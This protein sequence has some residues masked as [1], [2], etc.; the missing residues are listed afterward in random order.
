M[1]RPNI[2][3]NFIEYDSEEDEYDSEEENKYNDKY[4]SDDEYES[5]DNRS[6]KKVPDE[7]VPER[8]PNVK[9]Y[10]TKLPFESNY[11]NPFYI[12][13]PEPKPVP[14]PK[15]PRTWKTL[16]ETDT[17]VKMDFTVDKN[18]QE[19]QERI[20]ER[21]ERRRKTIIENR[22]KEETTQEIIDT[23][24]NA[25][26]NT[27]NEVLMSNISNDEKIKELNHEM[28][29]FAKYK[30]TELSDRPKSAEIK[31]SYMTQ[32]E[33]W[34]KLH[35]KLL[36]GKKLNT[37][38][39]TQYD[40][41][42]EKRNICECNN[43]NIAL[44][45]STI[46]NLQAEIRGEERLEKE[47]KR[48]AAEK[49]QVKRLEEAAEIKRQHEEEIY[50]N[51]I[52]RI[53]DLIQSFKE[54]YS[55]ILNVYYMNN[56]IYTRNWEKINEELFYTFTKAESFSIKIT[57]QNDKIINKAGTLLK[58]NKEIIPIYSSIE[59]EL[60]GV[61]D[62]SYISN[63]ITIASNLANMACTNTDLYSI[64]IL[65]TRQDNNIITKIIIKF[66]K[67]QQ[68]VIDGLNS[69]DNLFLKINENPTMINNQS[70]LSNA[71]KNC[72]Q[73]IIET[74][75]DIT[76]KKNK[77]I[78]EENSI[79]SI[80]ISETSVN[81]TLFPDTEKPIIINKKERVKPKFE[82]AKKNKFT[83]KFDTN[84]DSYVSGPNPK[85]VIATKDGELSLEEQQA[86][87]IAAEERKNK[88]ELDKIKAQQVREEF[89]RNKKQNQKGKPK[90]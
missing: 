42:R 65:S 37:R 13:K 76:N 90:K 71:Q 55:D 66:T 45:K 7:I 82:Q 22:K 41:L 85:N 63:I 39:R 79:E 84:V 88:I 31:G 17:E 19:R 44:F 68:T 1:F 11:Q 29:E 77:E 43:K 80:P 83:G 38:E 14:I 57:A 21:A 56:I 51:R 58:E 74:K 73:Y 25:V 49:R 75:T 15:P 86:A 20:K 60:D 81:P 52:E 23:T 70:E 61:L 89:F 12:P 35:S 48:L 34:E 87:K 10:P 62:T 64:Q 54:M 78:D 18:E 6:D 28:I 40:L 26:R 5:D 24:D 47:R 30:R 59:Y 46:A 32:I 2:R 3:K 4:E 67:I 69:Y 9:L 27:I 53:N 8:D 72:K 36:S 50:N 33:F 16:L